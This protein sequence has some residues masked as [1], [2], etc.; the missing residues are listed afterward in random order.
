VDELPLKVDP[1]RWKLAQEWELDLWRKQ[2]QN[3][4][5]NWRNIGPWLIERIRSPE[6]DDWNFWWAEKFNNYQSLPRDFEN[7]I[8]LGCGPYTNMRLLQEGRHIKH[9]YCSD[10]LIL[11]YIKFKRAWLAKAQR[12]GSILIDDHSIE[13]LPFASNYFDLVLLVNV[14]D[15]VMDSLACLKRAISIVKTGGYLV[16][17][18]DLSDMEDV[19]RIG[20]DIGH[21]IRIDHATLDRELEAQYEVVHYEILGREKGRNPRAHYGTYVYIGRKVQAF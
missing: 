7:A 5:K 12:K 1:K 14:L 20:D 21:P 15:H 9:V 4:I 13:E 19:R 2:N 6:G 3:K 18:Q 10:P 16:V 8:E 11:H 17:G